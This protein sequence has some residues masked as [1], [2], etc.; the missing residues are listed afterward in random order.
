MRPNATL[1]ADGATELDSD[2]SAQA[3]DLLEAAVGASVL[4]GVTQE[5]FLEAAAMAWRSTS[6]PAPTAVKPAP[7]AVIGGAA[8]ASSG[9]LGRTAPAAGLYPAPSCESFFADGSD[10]ELGLPS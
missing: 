7:P 1:L 9:R 3:V 10:E 2:P 4:A 8:Q 6:S 5:Q